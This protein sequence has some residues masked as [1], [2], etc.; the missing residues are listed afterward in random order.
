[1]CAQFSR[2]ELRP[3]LECGGSTPF[4]RGDGRGSPSCLSTLHSQLSTPR[5]Y[6]Y[7]LP[8][9][10]NSMSPNPFV[11]N[12]VRT[13]GG[14]VPQFLSLVITA[15]YEH[16]RCTRRRYFQKGDPRIRESLTRRQAPVPNILELGS[17]LCRMYIEARFRRLTTRDEPGTNS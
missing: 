12:G 14:G 16:A 17:L 8:Q 1:M 5:I 2:H 3:P 9:L 7:D 6:L 13:P 15:A 4:T 11:F 10:R